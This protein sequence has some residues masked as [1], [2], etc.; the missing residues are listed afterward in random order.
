[1]TPRRSSRARTSQP[2]PALHHLNSSSSGNSLTRGERSTRSSNKLSSPQR[3]SNR[4]QSTDDVPQTR[5]R[6]ARDDDLDGPSNA[7]NEEE[8]EE[9]GDNDDEEITRCL[10]G[11]QEYPG[12][13][14]SRRAALSR[15]RHRGG[16]SRGS[17]GDGSDALGSDDIGSMFIQCDSCKVWQHGG[18]V[19]IM[20]EAMSPDEYFCEEC[21]RDLH[22]ITNE[23]NGA[24][25][26]QFLPV[27]A[28]SSPGS[29]S[30]ES[31]SDDRRK[32][33]Q[34]DPPKRRSTMN[35]REAAY[36]EEEQLRRAIEESKEE[37]RMSHDDAGSRRP[38][39]GRTDS[40]ATKQAVK[41]QRTSSP[42]PSE[43][44]QPSNP[45]S[46]PASDDE[47]K[48]KTNGTKRQRGSNR[49][50]DEPEAEAPE[51]TTRRKSR[52]DRRREESDHEGEASST[53]STGP[54][55]ATA[56]AEPS[57]ARPDTPVPP[58]EQAAPRASNRKSGRPPARRGGRSGRNHQ[59]R[60][61]DQANGD[62]RQS[63][64]S[65]SQRDRGRDSPQGANGAHVNGTEKGKPR[66][67][68]PHRTSM[69][70]LKRRVAAILDFISRMQVEMAV[71]GESSSTPPG[72]NHDNSRQGSHT[73]AV[74]G[75]QEK[76]DGMLQTTKDE[77]G[78]QASA[79][80]A[81]TAAD[82]Q[83]SSTG[84]GKNAA[85]VKERDFKDLSSVEMMDVL[86]RHLLKWQQ[87]Y[88]KLGEK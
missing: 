49:E 32:L 81:A 55:P 19:G 46:A 83:G 75:L 4:S 36:D 78:K 56:D 48:P 60:D 3:S 5:Q 37:A 76:L 59:N 35:S 80:G 24:Q 12:L 63:P 71:S 86:T 88:G 29:T 20:D 73:S 66:Y 9:E 18:C 8:E 84:D 17:P 28:T 13:P 82:G 1:M 53:K 33:R 77:T 39:R 22:K 10:C 50:L 27:A 58:T 70:E 64:N 52:S 72:G 30:R 34:N 41:R 57:E 38:K 25:S 45:A 47:S 65:P 68:N 61:R 87:E 62:G 69:T 15:G 7:R 21:R 11:Q 26:S 40:E 42:S 67:L 23:S 43:V 2:S 54:A 31:S 51:S 44:A 14:P 6:R 74:Q 85:T 16:D 79:D